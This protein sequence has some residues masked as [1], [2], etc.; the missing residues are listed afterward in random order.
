MSGEV[1]TPTGFLPAPY[2]RAGQVGPTLYLSGYASGR[3]VGPEGTTEVE[4]AER[5]ARTVMEAMKASLDLADMTM[6][7]LVYVQV[8]A[9][10]LADYDAFN[11]VYRTYFAE[12]FPAR[13][14]LGVAGLLGD[15][16]FEVQA[17]AVKR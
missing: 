11:R 2:S 12:E 17:I 4:A 9:T 8:F 14:F 15:S 3:Y 1:D 13:A 16:R 7:D 5:E 6:A 10:D